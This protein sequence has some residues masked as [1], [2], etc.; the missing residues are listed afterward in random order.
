MA[1]IP[2]SGMMFQLQDQ[3]DYNQNYRK[4]LLRMVRFNSLLNTKFWLTAS[5]GVDVPYNDLNF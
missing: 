3:F 4:S 5:V 2:Y 1:N